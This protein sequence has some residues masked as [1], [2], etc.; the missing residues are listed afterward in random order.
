MFL[1]S[2]LVFLG[3]GLLVSM[4]NFHLARYTL[5]I[6]PVSCLIV[7]ILFFYFAE[8]FERLKFAAVLFIGLPFFYYSSDDFNFDA[9]MG[10]LHIVRTQQEVSEYLNGHY[11][12]SAVILTDFPVNFGLLDQKAGYV[13]HS[14]PNQVLSCNTEKGSVA[15]VY[16]YTYPGNLEY[17][18]PD[19]RYLRLVKEYA[20]SFSRASIYTRLK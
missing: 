1:L 15:D 18:K 4:L 16:V 20:S 7:S 9:D 19:T 3:F 10:Y 12:S 13:Q 2:G 11:P 6:L 5:F 14:Y 17:C 8:H